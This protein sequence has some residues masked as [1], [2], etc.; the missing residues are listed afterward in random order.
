ME[1]LKWRKSSG[2]Q[3][4]NLVFVFICNRWRSLNY[5]KTSWKTCCPRSSL[6]AFWLKVYTFLV[7]EGPFRIILEAHSGHGMAFFSVKSLLTFINCTFRWVCFCLLTDFTSLSFTARDK[8]C[9]TC[10][11]SG[12]DGKFCMQVR[13][14]HSAPY[15]KK[16]SLLRQTFKRVA[17]Y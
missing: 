1:A 3:S 11:S 7:S 4:C 13:W 17:K 8:C 16:F 5:C 9:K 2:M 10:F 12:P 6:H 14:V 15:E